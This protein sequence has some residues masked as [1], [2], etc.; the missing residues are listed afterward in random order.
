[1]W[2]PVSLLVLVAAAATFINPAP[3]LS[4][5]PVVLGAPTAWATYP[6]P[7]RTTAAQSSWEREV[8]MLN[9]VNNERAAAG[10]APLMPHATIRSVAR[11]HGLEMVAFGYLSHVDRSGLG[12]QQRVLRRGVRVRLVGENI[13]YAATIREAHEALMTSEAHREN[14]LLPDYR[15]VGIGVIDGGPYGVVVVENFGD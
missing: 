4:P 14:I 12:P 3:I 5:D 1:M 11:A 9:L 7:F 15:L 6:L 10:L 13:A 8:T 2:R